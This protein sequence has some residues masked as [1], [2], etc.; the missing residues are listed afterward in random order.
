MGDT[1]GHNVYKPLY[2]MY[3]SI[4]VGHL[5][6]VIHSW[7]TV[8]SDHLVNLLMDLSCKMVEN[9]PEKGP[10]IASPGCDGTHVIPDSRDQGQCEL[11]RDPS[12]RRNGKG[13][14]LP[15]NPWHQCYV[16]K[17]N[18]RSKGLGSSH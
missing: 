8:C 3:D 4:S 5:G 1:Q 18:I 9:T 2:L 11:R 7:G 15:S 17:D 10:Q 14:D 12:S 16:H 13:K 6:P